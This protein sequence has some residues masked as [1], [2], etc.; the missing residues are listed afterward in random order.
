[1]SREQEAKRRYS[2][3]GVPWAFLAHR[4]EPCLLTWAHGDGVDVSG[5]EAG[6]ILCILAMYGYECCK[7]HVH[8]QRHGHIHRLALT[9]N[10]WTLDTISREQSNINTELQMIE[11]GGHPQTR[12]GVSPLFGV[13]DPS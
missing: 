13:T 3:D 5:V 10:S 12:E 9:S 7:S 1:M 11:T 2:V 6:W 8:I 4:G